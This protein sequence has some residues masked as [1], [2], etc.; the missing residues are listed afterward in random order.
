MGLDIFAYRVKNSIIEK[1]NISVRSGYSDIIPFVKEIQFQEFCKK[2][3]KLVKKLSTDFEKCNGNETEYIKV[4]LKFIKSVEQIPLYSS[5]IYKFT[6]LGFDKYND[7]LLNVL[8]P[9]DVE[10][11]FNK[12]KTD[13][14]LTENV[15]FRKVNFPLDPDIHGNWE[16]AGIYMGEKL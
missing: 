10:K 2:T 1:N 16:W 12:D 11:I 9:T 14:F 6:S 3:D 13:F 5:Y 7:T 4:Y 8:Y 15:Y